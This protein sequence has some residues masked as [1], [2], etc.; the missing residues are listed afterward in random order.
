MKDD[1][2]MRASRRAALCS[3]ILVICSLVLAVDGRPAHAVDTISVTPA[4]VPAFGFDAPDPDVVVAGDTYYAYTTGT[5]WGN[6]IGILRSSQPDTGWQTI[7]GTQFGS[8]AFPSVSHV[9]APAPWQVPATQHAPGVFFRG[10]RWVMYYGAQ[11]KATGRWCLAIATATSPA[12]PFVDRTGSTPWFCLDSFGGVTDPSPFVDANGRAWLHFKSNTGAVVAPARLWAV[13]LSSD[14]MRMTSF[15][16]IVLT[17]LTGLYPWQTTIENPQMFIRG[18]QYYL[19]FSGGQWDGPDYG[20]AYAVCQGPAGPCSLPLPTPFLVKYG[21]VLGPGGGS[22]FVD[23]L[24]RAWLAY[25]GWNGPCTSY[26][27]GGAR[28]LFVAPLEFAGMQVPCGPPANQNGYRMVAADGGIFAFGSMTFCGSAAS[29][30]LQRSIVAIATTPDRGGYWL[31]ASDG[32]VYAFGNARFHG[33][34]G[35]VINS[36]VVGMAAAPDGRGYWL[37]ARDGGIFAFG[38]ARFFGS[39]GG[40]RLNQPVV[41]MAAAPDGRGYWLVARDG[42]IFAFGSARFFGSTG[43]IRLNQPIVGMS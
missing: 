19:L 11:N 12:G 17:Q 33:S 6:H 28:L 5:S 37:V 15:P 22:A 16:Q 26:S 25:H 9:G 43:S 10:G 29:V 13:Q 3:A 14:G 34:T 8:S 2:R 30:F 41:G 36:P 40:L 39:T 32:A 27:C 35:G 7:T 4:P 20:Q 31:G 24:G 18:G 42:G 38:S 23:P 21:A 1:V